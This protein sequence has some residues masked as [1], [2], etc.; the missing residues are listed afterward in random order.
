MCAGRTAGRRACPAIGHPGTR[1]RVAEPLRNQRERQG[2]CPRT[3]SSTKAI[4]SL[5]DSAQ[6]KTTNWGGETAL[7]ERDR[8]AA[9]GALMIGPRLRPVPIA[10]AAGMKELLDLDDLQRAALGP[11]RQQV[12]DVVGTAHA[13]P[14]L[15]TGPHR[16][17]HRPRGNGGAPRIR[18]G[19]GC[20][21]DPLSQDA[22]R[23][24]SARPG[25]TTSA[26]RGTEPRALRQTQPGLLT[27]PQSARSPP[28]GTATRRTRCVCALESA[29][30]RAH[31][32]HNV[33]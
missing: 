5:P 18:S 10:T 22:D 15:W 7:A 27:T 24:D 26:Q 25:E 8:R 19:A 29:I 3:M 23:R 14:A 13:R 30:D 32:E 9:L 31:T 28:G 1:R 2:T 16:R 4:P 11:R 17:R 20:V 12:D 21:H 33:R 6:I